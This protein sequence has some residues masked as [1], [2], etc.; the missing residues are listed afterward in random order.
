M[1]TRTAISGTK[2]LAG[3][4]GMAITIRSAMKAKAHSPAEC[5]MSKLP[6]MPP[7]HR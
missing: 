2:A 1:S 5:A 6:S 4:A 7:N 3:I